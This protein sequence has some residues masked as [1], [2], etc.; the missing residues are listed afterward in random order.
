MSIPFLT[1]IS[2][3]ENKCTQFMLVQE[4]VIHVIII[5]YI[6][7]LNMHVFLFNNNWNCILNK[8]RYQYLYKC[9]A[10]SSISLYIKIYL[11]CIFTSAFYKHLH[12]WTSIVTFE[13]LDLNSSGI[14]PI[15]V[16]TTPLDFLPV[17][18]YP[19]L[20]PGLCTLCIDQRRTHT[21][22]SSR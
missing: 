14:I 9:I 8:S 10:Y 19:V 20:D 22:L 12:R 4:F 17:A 16:T 1:R 7:N 21:R 13:F 5:L 18:E 2:E 6:I 11:Q 3:K 15:T